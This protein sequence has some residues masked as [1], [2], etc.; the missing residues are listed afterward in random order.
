[1]NHKREGYLAIAMI[2][3]VIN[4]EQIKDLLTKI[5]LKLHEKIMIPLMEECLDKDLEELSPM[6]QASVSEATLYNIP[7]KINL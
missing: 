6:L 3:E 2:E 1:M 7:K 4:N 5:A